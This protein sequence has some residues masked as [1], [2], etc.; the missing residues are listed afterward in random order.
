MGTDK[1]K[2]N[3]AATEQT[4]NHG[5]EKDGRSDNICECVQC[6]VRGVERRVTLAR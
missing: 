2:V 5:E 1:A 4:V 3:E 6:G